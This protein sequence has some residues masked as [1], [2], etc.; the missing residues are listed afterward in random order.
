MDDVVQHLQKIEAIEDIKR[1]KARY[2]RWIDTKQWE[3]LRTVFTADCTF[4]GLWAGG[5]GADAFVSSI[6]SNLADVP[7]VHMGFMPEIEVLDEHTARG[8]WA[9]TDYL[10]WETDAIA[11]RGVSV[12]GQR[13]I[14]GYGHYS[15]EY[16]RTEDGW[17][18]S[19]LRMTRL[20]IDPLVGPLE[21]E[22]TNF[23]PP[24]ADEWLPSD[25][26]YDAVPGDE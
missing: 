7:T 12:P 11:Y 10:E 24:V 18:I 15:E 6:Q 2:F 1:L 20:R 16:T 17:K 21:P 9:M 26:G 5:D 14:R 13:G 8:I 25:R 22:H 3:K 19:H 4:E 23:M